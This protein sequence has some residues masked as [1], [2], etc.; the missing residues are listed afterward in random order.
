MGLFNELEVRLREEAIL[1]L[2]QKIEDGEEMIKIERVNPKLDDEFIGIYS[3]KENIDL[4][5]V[6]G[7][8][9]Y[10]L[11]SKPNRYA[12][13][14]NYYDLQRDYISTYVE[15]RLNVILQRL[16]NTNSENSQEDIVEVL[17]ED[18]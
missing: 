10:G 18:L 12:S 13:I 17:L 8:S 2:N 16:V 5:K 9:V 6:K 3:F 1:E 4:K 15:D 11:N 7:I 14:T